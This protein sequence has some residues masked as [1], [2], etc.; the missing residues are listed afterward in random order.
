VDR[1]PFARLA[2]AAALLGAAG[3]CTGGAP[4]APALVPGDSVPAL[5]IGGVGAGAGTPLVWVFRT[6]DCLTCQ[7][8]DYPLRRVQ[9]AYGARVPL[10]AVHVGATADSTV[11]RSY[12]A[13]KRLNVSRL[14]TISPREFRRSFGEPGLPALYMVRDGRV[15]WSS[16]ARIDP[17]AGP[18]RL[19]SL[20]RALRA[21][22]AVGR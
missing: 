5:W 2:A 15:A 18:V 17:G 8:L 6:E 22:T 21:E 12:F 11:A 9:A 16:N 13:R 4:A 10:V 7:G 14:V 1:G 19:D 20:L 3:A